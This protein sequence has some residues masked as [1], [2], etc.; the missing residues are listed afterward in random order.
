MK[1]KKEAKVGLLGIISL[2]VLYLGFNF[3]K[4]LDLFSTENEYKV[5][6]NDVNG[7][8]VSNAVTFKGVT[9]GRVMA[10]ETD[11]DND[12]IKCP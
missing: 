11:Q 3:L 4:G 6:F 10:M 7:L 8:Q 9:V 12:Q 5:V 2:A 1:F